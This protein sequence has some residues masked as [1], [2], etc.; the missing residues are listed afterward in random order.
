[1]SLG[2]ARTKKEFGTADAH[3]CT[4]MD[5]AASKAVGKSV[6]FDAQPTEIEQQAQ[7]KATSLEVID[8]LRGVYAIQRA[9]CLQ[10]NDDNALD[11]HIGRVF[12]NDNIIIPDRDSVLLCHAE[13]CLTQLVRQGVFVDLLEKSDPR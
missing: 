4:L 8:A 2:T 12:S 6:D 13:T 7:A 5:R 11:Q 9:H 10:V 1:M 3:R